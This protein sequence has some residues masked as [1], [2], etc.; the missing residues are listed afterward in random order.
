MIY[1]FVISVVSYILPFAH[2]TY[3]NLKLISIDSYVQSWPVTGA[4][5]NILTLIWGRKP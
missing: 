4:S 5:E 1:K 2:K 3:V